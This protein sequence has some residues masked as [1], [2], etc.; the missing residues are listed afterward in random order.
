MLVCFHQENKSIRKEGTENMPINTFTCKN[1]GARVNYTIQVN[2]DGEQEIE[3]VRCH[4]KTVI[5]YDD[6]PERLKETI[7]ELDESND[8]FLEDMNSYGADL[9]GVDTVE[10]TINK[11]DAAFEE[12][13]KEMN[14]FDSQLQINTDINAIAEQYAPSDDLFDVSNRQSN[15]SSTKKNKNSY[16]N[17]FSSIKEQTKEKLRDKTRS[18]AKKVLADRW[19][20]SEE[21]IADIFEIA[22]TIK[23]MSDSYHMNV[24]DFVREYP[25]DA[26]KIITQ[27]AKEKD[28][29]P[30]LENMMETNGFEKLLDVA[31][32][33]D[34]NR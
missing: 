18:Y 5:S 28:I 19:N 33:F 2:N 16:N 21:E 23:I 13:K 29:I 26:V 6:L 8:K 9:E 14:A 11:V 30:I 22:D 15:S 34:S 24:Q 27:K 7:V 12:A 4:E 1:C 31:L 20:A 17:S 32:T 10:E 25:D 3:C